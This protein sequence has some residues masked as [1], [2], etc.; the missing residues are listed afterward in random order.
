MFGSFSK[1]KGKVFGLMAMKTMI[2]P[3]AQKPPKN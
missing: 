3:S 2:A 1:F